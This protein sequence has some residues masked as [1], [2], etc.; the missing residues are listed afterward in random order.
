M[1]DSTCNCNI[2]DAVMWIDSIYY[3]NL[4]EIALSLSKT[5]LNLG[6]AAM[7][8]YPDNTNLNR[9]EHHVSG[10]LD[11]PVKITINGN[12]VRYKHG[13]MTEFL[14]TNYAE[15][16]LGT[17]VWD[18]TLRFEDTYIFEL[19]LMTDDIPYSSDSFSSYSSEDDSSSDSS[20][21]GERL[22]KAINTMASTQLF[23]PNNSHNVLKKHFSTARAICAKHQIYDV[24]TLNM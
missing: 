15:T 9:G 7:H 16:A 24:A 3:P 5:N 22:E 8:I 2:Y 1:C 11:G 14:H 12:S 4:D 13:R 6:Y 10:P 21:Y 19:S 23:S 20:D 18:L 17:L